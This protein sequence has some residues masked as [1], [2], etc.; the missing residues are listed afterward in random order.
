MNLKLIFLTI[1]LSSLATITHAQ[2]DSLSVYSDSTY[3][4]VLI[5]DNVYD[6]RV[7]RTFS[8]DSLPNYLQINNQ[9]SVIVFLIRNYLGFVEGQI[10]EYKTTYANDIK[11]TSYYIL[12]ENR[13]LGNR[14]NVEIKEYMNGTFEVHYFKKLGSYELFFTAHKASLK[15]IESI[16]AYFKAQET[17]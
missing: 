13:S 10:Q 16:K 17:H 14:M 15:E 1:L 6:P 11:I 12:G 7:K 2:K 5:F 3:N 9:Q 8:A 4:I